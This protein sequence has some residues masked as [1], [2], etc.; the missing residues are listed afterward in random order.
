MTIRLL[1][2][3]DR[4]QARDFWQ[5]VFDDP[6][7]FVDWFFENRYM[8]SWS[9]GAFDGTKLISAV[10]GMPMDL[11]LG[12]TSFPAL[13]TSGVATAPEE[14]GRGHMY[15]VMRFL[16]A[17]AHRRGV[18][19]L[20]NHPQRPGAYRHLGF[21]PSTFTKYWQG[22]GEY[23][24]WD[25]APFLEEEAFRVYTAVSRRYTGFV[26][27]D[28]GS[29][30]RKM[31]D[32]ASDGAQAFLLKQAGETAGYCIFFDKQ[33]VHGEEVLSLT[34]YGPLLGELKRIAGGKR[35]CAKLPP[36]A[37]APGQV[38]AQNVMLA[39]EHIWQDMEA[40]G[41]PCFCVDEY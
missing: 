37:E 40:T 6:P 16:Q 33:D 8:P 32:Y 10:H 19:A 38:L 24:P 22:E 1:T 15:A 31:A 25:I 4:D 11:S 13:M 21:R 18:K 17:E 29:F 5:S 27:R 12:D 41:L 23:A 39:P 30:R 36:D 35:V 14:R 2:A 3:D 7:A 20:F 9:A 26:C 28:R 34:E